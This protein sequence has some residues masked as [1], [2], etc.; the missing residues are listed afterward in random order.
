MMTSFRLKVNYHM[1]VLVSFLGLNDII[2]AIGRL[3]HGQCTFLFRKYQ[4]VY[5]EGQNGP[6]RTNFS[7]PHILLTPVLII[8]TSNRLKKASHVY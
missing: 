3:L 1:P 2:Q 5:K 8:A 6:N 4:N 7:P